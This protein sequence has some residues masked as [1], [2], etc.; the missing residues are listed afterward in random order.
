[1]ICDTSRAPSFRLSLELRNFVLAVDRFDIADD[2]DFVRCDI[3]CEVPHRD[4]GAPFPLHWARFMPRTMTD[5]EI[6]K[7]IYAELRNMI[8]HELA[9]AWIVGDDRV[10]DPH[11]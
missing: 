8:V 11:G 2:G 9:E 1:M 6:A 3:V 4:T 7:D 10:H 5:H